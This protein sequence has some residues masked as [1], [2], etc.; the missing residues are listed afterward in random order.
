MRRR[1]GAERLGIAGGAAK[2]ADAC[3]R[4][5]RCG[6]ADLH[7]AGGARRSG[8]GAEA[9]Q[10]VAP[11]CCG[12]MD[13]SGGGEAWPPARGGRRAG[14][15]PAAPGA[16]RWYG[17]EAEEG[18]SLGGREREL[19]RG[20]ELGGDKKRDERLTGRGQHPT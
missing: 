14:L 6:R 12:G 2:Q 16:G 15:L 9:G 7:A 5:N 8:A 10:R 11:A 17:E 18:E 19:G 13:S 1:V 3:R 4:R 20:G